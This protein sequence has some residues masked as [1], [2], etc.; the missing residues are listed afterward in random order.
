MRTLL[1]IFLLVSSAFI[2]Q[3]QGIRLGFVVSGSIS[4]SINHSS[5]S[6][7]EKIKDLNSGYAEGWVQNIKSCT[8]SLVQ[9]EGAIHIESQ[10]DNLNSAQLETIRMA[11]CGDEIKV[12]IVYVFKNS[13]TLIESDR[14]IDFS[15]IVLPDVQAQYQSGQESLD[16]YISSTI[17]NNIRL[18]EVDDSP[19]AHGYFV[20]DEKGNASKL[21]I[22]EKSN[23]AEIEKLLDNAIIKM[24]KWTPARL[25]DGTPVP[26]KINFIISNEMGC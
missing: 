18:V 1:F 20:V 4:K 15:V 2:S 26:Q 11:N 6:K 25:K 12:R 7:V 9:S 13:I 23:S 3:A 10:S 22:T 8:V 16:T 24:P 21:T 17:I 19:V 14:T 5:L